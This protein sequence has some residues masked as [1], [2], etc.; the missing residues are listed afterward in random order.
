MLKRTRKLQDFLGII[1]KVLLSSLK[2]NSS[3]HSKFCTGLCSSL[4]EDRVKP[5]YSILFCIV[6]IHCDFF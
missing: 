1:V 2:G 6:N 3:L 5:H 4:I